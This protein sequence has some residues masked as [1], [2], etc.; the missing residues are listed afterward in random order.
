ML[1]G[2]RWQMIH[3][4][5]GFRYQDDL[6]TSVGNGSRASLVC[7]RAC[8]LVCLHVRYVATWPAFALSPTNW[9]GPTAANSNKKIYTQENQIKHRTP[10]C[11]VGQLFRSAA[12][13]ITCLV[14]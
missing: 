4:V 9:M 12:N 11:L 2:L 8:L 7:Q 1:A 10:A 13:F 6:G 5:K 3:F 14:T